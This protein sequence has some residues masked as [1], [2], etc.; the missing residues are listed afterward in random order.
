MTQLWLKQYTFDSTLD[1]NDDQR[2]ST[3]TRL[4]SLIFTADSILTRLIWV[5]VESKLTHDSWVEHYP[6]HN[7]FTLHVTVYFCFLHSS[8]RSSPSAAGPDRHSLPSLA[9][10]CA[11]SPHRLPSS[12]LPSPPTGA[13]A[14]CSDHTEMRGVFTAP[15]SRGNIA[16]WIARQQPPLQA[17]TGL[18]M[19]LLSVVLDAAP[20]LLSAVARLIWKAGFELKYVFYFVW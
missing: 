12:L 5:R 19:S 14:F 1:S 16:L 10:C 2:D 9:G 8:P 7:H 17:S 4:I 11:T 18:E 13:V 15:A 3:L 20:E 6:A